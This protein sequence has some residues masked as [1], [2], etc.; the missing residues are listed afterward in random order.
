MDLRSTLKLAALEFTAELMLHDIKFTM[1]P[2]YSGYQWTFPG[3]VLEGGD[4]TL[5]TYTYGWEAG[6]LESYRMPWDYDDVSVLL[7]K[8]MAQKIV[9]AIKGAS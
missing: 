8:E 7:P 6:F 9:E 1:K 5:N 2:H 4:V 3:T